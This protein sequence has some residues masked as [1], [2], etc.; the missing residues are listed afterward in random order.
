MKEKERNYSPISERV[1][2]S[3]AMRDPRLSYDVHSFDFD[4]ERDRKIYAA[5]N[6]GH[7]QLPSNLPNKFFHRY[8]IG[9]K[10]EPPKYLFSAGGLLAGC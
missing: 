5:Y 7:A 10:L 3:A 8:P 2:I 4:Y 6:K 9:D 1:W